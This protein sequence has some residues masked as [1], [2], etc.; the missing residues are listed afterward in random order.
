VNATD[1]LA[2]AGAGNTTIAGY[3]YAG[4]AFA[5]ATTPAAALKK[6]FIRAL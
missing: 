2:R 3:V 5:T 4:E 1:R 6:V